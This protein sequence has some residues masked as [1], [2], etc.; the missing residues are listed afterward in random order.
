M[1]IVNVTPDSFSDGGRFVEAEAAID[2]GER[3]ADGSVTCYRPLPSACDY[4]RCVKAPPDPVATLAELPLCC[5]N[6]DCFQLAWG[7]YCS[8]D[9]TYCNAPY[10]NT[11]GSVGC[12][13]DD[14]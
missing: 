4:T 14:G 13:D 12:A 9:I 2:H 3:L 10:S 5:S 8:A 7:E 1:G 6:G 11:D